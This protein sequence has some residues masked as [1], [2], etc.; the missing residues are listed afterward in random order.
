MY[1][2]IV[3]TCN[4]CAEQATAVFEAAPTEKELHLMRIRI[5]D[6]H[7]IYTHVYKVDEFGE[8]AESYL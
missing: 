5:G 3:T 8:I 1:I 6:T 2:A 4:Q 7:C